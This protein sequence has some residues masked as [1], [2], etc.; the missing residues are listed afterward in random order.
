MKK[1]LFLF[2]ALSFLLTGIGA[3]AQQR[4]ENASRSTIA[5]VN[6]DKIENSSRSTI[7]YFNGDRV[8]NRNRST[9]GYISNGRVENSS[10]STIGY[11]P[12]SV[13]KDWIAYYFFFYEK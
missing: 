11:Y 12:T 4:I 7:L 10:R 2:F 1:I 6:N 13:R 3:R 5:Y 8:E 9:I